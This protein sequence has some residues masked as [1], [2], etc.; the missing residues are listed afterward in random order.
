M[1]R[2]K[3]EV[4]FSKLPGIYHTNIPGVFCFPVYD[5]D[6]TVIDVITVH[7][8][9]DQGYSAKLGELKGARLDLAKEMMAELRSK[10]FAR[11]INSNI[12]LN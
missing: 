11:V 8:I 5:D 1:K 4:D 9:R 10:P 12:L 2:Y 7:Q 6:Y 3:P